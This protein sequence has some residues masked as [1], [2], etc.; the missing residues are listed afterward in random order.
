MNIDLAHAGV[1]LRRNQ[2]LP[3]PSEPGVQILVVFGCVWITQEGDV[4]DY[5]LSSGEHMLVTKPGLTLVLA[6]EDSTVSLL[7]PEEHSSQAFDPD[8]TGHESLEFYMR[9][10]KQ[11]RSEYI[12]QVLGHAGEAITQFVSGL[13]KRAGNLTRWRWPG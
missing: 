6:L 5:I 9:K 3:V 13:R 10:A 7:R 2:S 8:M 4:R 1:A 11:L 12:G